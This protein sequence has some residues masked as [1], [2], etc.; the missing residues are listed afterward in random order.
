MKNI[1]TK[2][3]ST[4]LKK[5]VYEKKSISYDD[6]KDGLIPRYPPFLKGIPVASVSR[7]VLDQEEV[8]SRIRF[9][10][11][12]EL[13]EAYYHPAI[14]RYAAFVHL[15]PASEKHHHR[16]AGGLLRHGLEVGYN[17]I[18]FAKGKK[19]DTALSPSEREEN[20]P[21]WVLAAFLSGLTHDLGKPLSDY[22]VISEDGKHSWNP[23]AS[24]IEEWATEHGLQRYF[25]NWHE[26]RYR[27]HESLSSVIAER[28]IDRNTMSFLS[29]PTNAIIRNMFE[30]ITNQPAFDNKLY[31]IVEKSDHLSTEK[32]IKESVLRG[33]NANLSIP[34]EKYIIDAVKLL[35]TKNEWGEGFND[36]PP[37][38]YCDDSLFL[39]APALDR[40]CDVLQDRKVPGIPADKKSLTEVLINSGFAKHRET[41]DGDKSNV[42]PILKSG[43]EKTIWCIRFKDWSSIYPFKPESIPG[44]VIANLEDGSLS[45][46]TKREPGVL[47]QS[48]VVAEANPVVNA[49]VSETALEHHPDDNPIESSIDDSIQSNVHSQ[50]SIPPT[51][52]KE[53]VDENEPKEGEAPIN[54]T[55][56]QV[57]NEK[58]SQ[59][60]TP[61]VS[62]KSKGDVSG[63]LPVGE[64]PKAPDLP[65]ELLKKLRGKGVQSALF[66]DKDAVFIDWKALPEVL[67]TP[68][69]SK[70]LLSAN[71]AVKTNGLLT[72]II[73]EKPCIQISKKFESSDW[74][75]KA[76]NKPKKKPAVKRPAK[77]AQ[78]REVPKD[79]V[80]NGKAANESDTLAESASPI[81]PNTP[82]NEVK[83]TP[84]ASQTTDNNIN[85][86]ERAKVALIALKTV[87][88]LVEKSGNLSLL[89]LYD[90]VISYE[91]PLSELLAMAQKSEPA[92]YK[93]LK[94]RLGVENNG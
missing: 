57:A 9:E 32:D 39:T 77:I 75:Q 47:P 89:S 23:F 18:I 58:A 53:R 2:L 79:F 36:V 49:V 60:N 93:F 84:K 24:S 31:E 26:S 12:V 74:V 6:D 29:T 72:C 55:V 62:H 48:S 92:I 34:V 27:K 38:I 10:V 88:S 14:V 3:L 30:C 67:Q 65:P 64:A 59:S 83:K 13:Y 11:G 68:D 90:R 1:V 91:S 51:T 4:L 54:E 21:K 50:E 35:N 94:S 70:E 8:L 7:I 42:W 5:S 76:I 87:R 37:L 46:K 16:G 52:Q 45:T 20:A 41:L 15:L 56:K 86:Y 22:K 17:A 40:V 61:V 43:H 19:F 63:G 25:L 73:N 80:P 78:H 85:E 71:V 33:E 44:Y 82:L 66:V 81:A 69:F 28:I